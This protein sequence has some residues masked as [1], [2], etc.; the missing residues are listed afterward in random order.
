MTKEELK[1]ASIKC[2]ISKKY[3]INTSN[4][5]FKYVQCPIITYWFYTVIDSVIY[6]YYIDSFTTMI[7][8]I[9][10]AL[11]KEEMREKAL[12]KLLK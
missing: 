6:D 7:E 5:V 2:K 11:F 8:T 12:N 3:N 9:E 10:Y 1:I 4:I